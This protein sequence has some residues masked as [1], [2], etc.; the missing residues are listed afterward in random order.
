MSKQNFEKALRRELAEL[1]D[2]IDRKIIKGLPYAAEAR[3]H[4]FVVSRISELRRERVSWMV[5]SLTNFS[6]I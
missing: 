6:I 4:K 1:N 2:T 5:R 3:R